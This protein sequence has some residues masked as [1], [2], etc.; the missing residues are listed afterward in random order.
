MTQLYSLDLFDPNPYQPRTRHD[1]EHI[2]ALAISIAEQGLLQ[3]PFG[4]QVGER[5]QLAFGHSRL[6]AF[7]FLY[8]TGNPGFEKMP[9]VLQNLSDE[10][11]FD[12]AITENAQRQDLTVLETAKAMKRYREE[13]GK[14]SAEIGTL[15]GLSES[16]VRNKI[17]LL[18]LPAEVIA[19][20]EGNPVSERVLRELLTLFDLPEVARQKAEQI[21]GAWNVELRPSY[22][23]RFALNGGT[24]E[25]VANLTDRMIHAIG[26]DMSDSIFKHDQ[27]IEGD[28]HSPDCRSCNLRLMVDKKPFCLDRKCYERKQNAGKGIYLAKASEVCGIL[29]I[30]DSGI[31]SHEVTTW[32][33]DKITKI[34]A[35][36]CENL[37][38]VYSSYD[39]KEKGVDGFLR[40]EVCCKKTR[41]HCVCTQAI[42]AGVDP[43]YSLPKTSPA[44]EDNNSPAEPP[45]SARPAP[46]TADQLKVI[47]REIRAKKRDNLEECKALREDFTRR[48][49]EG[50]TGRN[51]AIWRFLAGELVSYQKRENLDGQPVDEI[52]L[53]MAEHLAAR[54]YD[55]TYSAPDPL[56]VLTAYNRI[57]QKAGLPLMENVSTE[58]EGVK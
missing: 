58:T 38:L 47:N 56:H 51:Q 9:V 55:W 44:Q 14:T 31:Q 6:E 43:A 57:L 35:T 32:W 4:R 3:M 30:E 52:W 5:I 40:A 7:K 46:L 45:Q 28:F 17:R 23:V 2:K 20:L 39:Q 37:R 33:G 34:K 22:V 18:N 26:V 49:Y 21:E 8:E 25:Q 1:D 15:F 19:E 42:D 16:A 12:L 24:S 53:A 50:L 13:F 10:K 41:G 36:G 54:Q 29:P 27:L 48:I 11:M